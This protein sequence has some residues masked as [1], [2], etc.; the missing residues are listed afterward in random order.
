MLSLIVSRD[1]SFWPPADEMIQPHPIVVT[2]AKHLLIAALYSYDMIRSGRS[3]EPVSFL[4][5]PQDARE[6]YLAEI[7][8]RG[9]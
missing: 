4:D 2:L 1:D 6:R 9:L 5:V 7:E 8:K 3:E